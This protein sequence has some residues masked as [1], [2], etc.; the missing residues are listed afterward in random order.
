M[1][2]YRVVPAALLLIYAAVTVRVDRSAL[3]ARATGGAALGPAAASALLVVVSRSLLVPDIV[4]RCRTA[5]YVMAAQ[6]YLDRQQLDAVYGEL[7]DGL[8]C[9]ATGPGGVRVP[10]GFGMFVTDFATVARGMGRTADAALVLERLAAIYRDPDAAAG[11]RRAPA[12]GQRL[13]EVARPR[14]AL[15]PRVRGG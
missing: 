12:V 8:E 2:R 5:E 15:T 14:P 10:P 11:H 6:T 1:G 7:R 3:F 9:L 4:D 13:S